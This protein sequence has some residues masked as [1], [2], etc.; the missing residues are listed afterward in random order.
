ML[1]ILASSQGYR[2]GLKSF[3]KYFLQSV[4]MSLQNPFS[5]FGRGYLLLLCRLFVLHCVISGQACSMDGLGA[6]WNE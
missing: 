5:W 3:R 4:W 6:A 2:S 1:R